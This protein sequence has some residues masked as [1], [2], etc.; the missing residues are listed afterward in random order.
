MYLSMQYF[1][2]RKALVSGLILAGLGL[3]TLCFSLLVQ[4]YVNPDNLKAIKIYADSKSKYFTGDSVSV[5]EKVPGCLRILALIWM[6]LAI[7]AGM[8]QRFPKQEVDPKKKQDGVLDMDDY[9]LL[10]EMDPYFM[11]QIQDIGLELENIYGDSHQKPEKRD[12]VAKHTEPA[13]EL[14]HEKLLNANK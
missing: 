8:L 10:L 2:K 6:V 12:Q 3:G 14:S 11:M 5:A 1:P 9:G 13:S 7:L 4:N